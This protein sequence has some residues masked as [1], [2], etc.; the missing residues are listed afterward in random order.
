MDLITVL[1]G[2][3]LV[4]N[5]VPHFVQGITGQR[6][7]T[8]FEVRS[9]PVVNVLWGMLNIGPGLWLVHRAGAFNRSV[10]VAAALGVIVTAVGLA[11]FWS[12]DDR[13]LPWH[14]SPP[15]DSDSP[16]A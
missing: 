5:G 12:R 16:P 3:V 14:G 13:R 2:A 1:I 11:W 8:P 15:R 4:T 7:M 6:H 10:I 9:S